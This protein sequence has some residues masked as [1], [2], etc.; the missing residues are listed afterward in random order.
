MG[1]RYES[2]KSYPL[3]M[4]NLLQVSPRRLLK[5]AIITLVSALAVFR[6]VTWWALETSG[7]PV[8]ET[9]TPDGTL[10]STHVW[11]A[12]LDGEL[13]LEAGTPDNPWF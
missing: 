7:V 5:V 8:I 1:G 3:S 13:W 2:S 6:L 12:E 9:R 10:R 4:H 11:F